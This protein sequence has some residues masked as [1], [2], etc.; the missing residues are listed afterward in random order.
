MAPISNKPA[1]PWPYI[2]FS[3]QP[4]G[5]TRDAP[6]LVARQSAETVTVVSDSDG[7]GGGGHNLSG[8]AIAGIVIGTIAGTL[9]LLWLIRSCFNLGAPRQ[10]RASWY[11]GVDPE[12]SHRHSRHHHH[13]HGGRHHHRR[14]SRSSSSISTP[15][16]VVV[17][18]SRSRSR[19]G[20]PSYVYTT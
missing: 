15:P 6:T 1:F 2:A 7:G 16:P 8:G 19:H 18:S 4:T 10:E 11:N 9:L 3:P 14:R 13:H 20:R 5:T 17:Q 12:K